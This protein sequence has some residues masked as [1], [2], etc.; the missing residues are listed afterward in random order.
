MLASKLVMWGIEYSVYK[1][2]FL[3]IVAVDNFTS[4]TWKAKANGMQRCVETSLVYLLSFR[5]SRAT[6]TPVS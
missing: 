1:K 2:V 4:S 6:Q 3:Q 5:P